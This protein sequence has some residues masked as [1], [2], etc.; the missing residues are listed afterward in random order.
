MIPEIDI[1]RGTHLMIQQYRE[2][3]ANQADARVSDLF[4][5]GDS[6]AGAV[7]RRIREAIDELQNDTPD[8]STQ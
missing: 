5:R 8:D 4:E 2:N 7:W 3:T 1:W 6:A